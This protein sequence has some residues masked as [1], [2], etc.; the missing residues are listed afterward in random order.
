V[1]VKNP[2]KVKA[3]TGQ[4]YRSLPYTSVKELCIEKLFV[5]FI[6][7]NSLSLLQQD[8]YLETPYNSLLHKALELV[9]GFFHK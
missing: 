9:Q 1:V 6:E 3:K 4:V 2:V 7:V 8:E 5:N